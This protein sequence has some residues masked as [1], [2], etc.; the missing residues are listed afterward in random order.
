MIYVCA[1][2]HGNKAAFHDIIRQI[3]FKESDELY[4]LGDVID[5]CEYGIEILKWVMDHSNVHML[6]GNHEYM[7]LDA[8]GYPREK[9]IVQ[10]PTGLWYYNGGEV[11]HRDFKKLSEDEQRRIVEFLRALPTEFDVDVG[12]SIYKL[13]HANAEDV[14]VALSYLGRC[15]DPKEYFCVWDRD[16]TDAL[17]G[18]P[19]AKV[20]FGH[21]PTINLRP[22]IKPMT[23]YRHEKIIGIDCG[24][25]YPQ[26]GGRLACIRL[27]DERIFYSEDM[28]EKT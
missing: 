15:D 5:R 20:I 21:T 24:A 11:T 9:N 14:W 26:Y 6:L 22:D 19:F 27:D 16:Y 2:I 25:A 1:D 17:N 18:L 28:T 13:V 4:I 7:M 12:E 10:D 3:D 8:L 23:V